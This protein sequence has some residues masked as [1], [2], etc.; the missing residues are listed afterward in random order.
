MKLRAI[1]Y[2]LFYGIMPYWIYEHSK[3]YN[4][5]YWQHLIMNL[6]YAYR[7][8]INDIGYSDIKFELTTNAHRTRPDK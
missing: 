3:H 7:W 4:C 2:A 6:Q 5:S 1:K 8:L